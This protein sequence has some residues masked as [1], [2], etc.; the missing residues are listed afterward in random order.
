MDTGRR[1]R[2]HLRLQRLSHA[3]QWH[4]D[5]LERSGYALGI[6]LVVT[7]AS[8]CRPGS[9]P[10]ESA[11]SAAL[12]LQLH[13]GLSGSSNVLLP[14]GEYTTGLMRATLVS[15]VARRVTWLG[16]RRGQPSADCVLGFMRLW[17]GGTQLGPGFRRV[18]RAGNTGALAEMQFNVRSVAARCHAGDEYVRPPTVVAPHPGLG[19]QRRPGPTRPPPQ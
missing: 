10:P 17:I 8:G 3:L 4:D 16:V 2:R 9:R 1:P 19:C 18:S 6:G 7:R 11:H 14:Q 12:N 5:G 15:P 13:R